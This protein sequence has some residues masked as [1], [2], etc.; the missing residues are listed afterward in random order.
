LCWSN[1]LCELGFGYGVEFVDKN[2]SGG[3]GKLNYSERYGP[4]LDEIP[5]VMLT[6]LISELPN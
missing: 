4:C 3:G 6:L 1:V 2:C 5:V